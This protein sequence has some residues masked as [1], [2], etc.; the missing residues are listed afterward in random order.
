[1]TELASTGTC[2]CV[3]QC[4]VS[5]I[6]SC[7]TLFHRRLRMLEEMPDV[8]RSVRDVEERIQ[9]QERCSLHDC[10]RMFT[11]EEVVSES[12]NV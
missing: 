10:L 8:D 9:K 1:M 11:Q 2:S 6:Y 5:V 3:K 4:L 12:I 7:S